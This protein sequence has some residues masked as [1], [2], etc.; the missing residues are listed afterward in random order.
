LKELYKKADESKILQA[1]NNVSIS[2]KSLEI[3]NSELENLKITQSNSL[4]DLNKSI[5][6]SKKE[7]ENL[8]TTQEN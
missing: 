7:L 4:N 5:D 3:S 2:Q 6:I 8:K 1:Q